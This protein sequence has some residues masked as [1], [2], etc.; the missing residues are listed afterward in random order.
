M[1]VNRI[2]WKARLSQYCA[3]AILLLF[4]LKAGFHDYL[5]GSPIFICHFQLQDGPVIPADQGDVFTG[6]SVLPN[7]LS[8]QTERNLQQKQVEWQ[9]RN[10]FA[11]LQPNAFQPGLKVRDY[12]RYASA[13]MLSLD[14]TRIIFPFHTFI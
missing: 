14:S 2:N 12:I 3:I 8:T 13:I 6:Y 9:A 11:E 7:L 5:P 4:T 10:A 1:Q